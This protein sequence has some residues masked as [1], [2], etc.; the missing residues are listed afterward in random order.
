MDWPEYWIAASWTEN[1]Q[2]H[3][4]FTS[5]HGGQ[6]AGPYGAGD[7]SLGART[8]GMNLGSHVGDD[9][10]V[11][12]ANRARLGALS[13]GLQVAYLDQVHGTDVADL[14]A[15][16]RRSVPQADAAVTTTPGLA[17]CV[18][19]ADCLPVLFAAPDGSAV[20]AAHAGW[21]GLAG[22]VLENTLKAVCGKA[23]CEASAVQVWLG[24]AIGPQHFEVGED[25]RQAF[26]GQHAESASAFRMTR[27][28]KWMA[29]LF[30][31]ARLRLRAAGVPTSSV[32]GGG[33][34][35]VS[36]R[37]GYYSFRRDRITGRQA[38]L[39]WIAAPGA[40]TQR[41]GRPR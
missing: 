25:V 15:W 12:A 21:R 35:T 7:G 18:L 39:V 19:V 34:C 26:V 2:V 40:T 8:G 24:P 41:Q 36:E 23:Q 27:P 3:G 14:D 13:G 33:V 22:G 5:R 29:D 30:L 10:A 11:V 37:Q 6:S 4:V 17:A 38:G 16:D 32:Q 28:G 31:L 20:G 1:A 9:P